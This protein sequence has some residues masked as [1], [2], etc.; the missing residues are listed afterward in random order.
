MNGARIPLLQLVGWPC[1]WQHSLH[2]ECCDDFQCNQQAG[3]CELMGVASAE[4]DLRALM[5]AGLDGETAAHK[6][7]LERLSGHLRAFF[8]GQ[9][10]RGGR[11]PVDAEGAR[12]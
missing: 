6:A 7:L 11:G 1:G 10:A 4:P 9:L 12:H 8:R 5:L 2:L 3:S